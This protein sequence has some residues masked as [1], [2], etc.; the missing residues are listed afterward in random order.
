[1]RIVDRHILARFL[2]NFALLFA[3]LFVFAISIDIIIQW[4]KFVDAANRVAAS[5]DAASKGASTFEVLALI[6][7]FHGPRVFQ[8][9]QY[10]MPLVAMGAMGFTASAMHRNREFTALLASG[11]SLRRAVL[12]IVL[13]MLLLCGLQIANQEFAIPRLAPRLLLDHSD[14]QNGV[15]RTW[16]V[17]LATDS[18][19]RLIHA[20][21]YDPTTETLSG[22]YVV[23][24]T[25]DGAVARRI[26]AT[27]AKW[28][29][30]RG[31]WILKDGRAG[32]PTKPGGEP[33][34][35]RTPVFVD[36]PLATLDSDL[37]PK[38]LQL[39]QHAMFAHMLSLRE[40][41]QLAEGSA[42]DPGALRRFAV[43]RFS[44]LAVAIC[45]LLI[46]IPFFALREPANLL[47]QSVKCAAFGLP[48]LLMAMVLLSVPLERVPPTVGVILPV[49]CLLPVAAWR[50]AVIKT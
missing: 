22:V 40:I 3:L 15:A 47:A 5:R 17:P 21:S 9:Y 34:G 13:G 7:S 8:F 42:V 33:T 2:G 45:M 6:L 39:R 18:S 35:E 23:E 12:P 32:A 29:S 37:D 50:L 24:R 49:A 43:G 19:G 38:A 25:P 36:S 20:S 30:E 28:S 26:E 10:M 27:S 31:T 11:I 16:S 41:A 48:L 44:A 46:S 1:M 14:L 4:D